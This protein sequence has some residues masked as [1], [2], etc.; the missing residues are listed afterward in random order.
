MY[1]PEADR[2]AK[3]SKTSGSGFDSR[4]AHHLT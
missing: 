1:A 3:A 2:I 4:L